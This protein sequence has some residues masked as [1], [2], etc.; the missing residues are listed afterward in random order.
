MQLPRV[1]LWKQQSLLGREPKYWPQ[2]VSEPSCFLKNDTPPPTHCCSYPGAGKLISMGAGRTCRSLL[3]HLRF[4]DGHCP[5]P[6]PASGSLSPPLISASPLTTLPPSVQSCRCSSL[7]LG[8]KQNNRPQKWELEG[9][10]GTCCS[11]CRP[12]QSHLRPCWAG[13]SG[14]VRAPTPHPLSWSW[15]SH[16]ALC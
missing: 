8:F 16:T 1:W 6:L 11:C 15:Q 9:T 10:W 5:K 3:P 7:R 2:Q 4:L 14:R 12:R 13:S